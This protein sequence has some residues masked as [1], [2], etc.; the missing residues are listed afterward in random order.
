VI[1][2]EPDIVIVDRSWVSLGGAAALGLGCVPFSRALTPMA[3]L[4]RCLE[5]AEPMIIAGFDMIDLK[6]NAD[7]AAV[8]KLT[9][10]AV[11]LEHDVAKR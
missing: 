6:G 2:P 4:A 8:A 1:G 7:A 9:A 3:R 10:T 5:V 11:A